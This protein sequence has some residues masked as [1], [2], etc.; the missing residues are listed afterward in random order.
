[1]SEFWH[2]YLSNS[3]LIHLLNFEKRDFILIGASIMFMLGLSPFIGIMYSALVAFLIYFGIKVFVG[4][5]RRQ[6]L[7]DDGT[8][9]TT[10]TSLCAHCGTKLENDRC[11][12]CDTGN[13]STNPS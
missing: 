10:K 3:N 7:N 13:N 5:R 8:S 1:M 9:T 11:V 4:R 6:I 2:N 12:N